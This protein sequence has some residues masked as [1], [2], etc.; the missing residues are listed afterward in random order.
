MISNNSGEY[1]YLIFIYAECQV[2]FG[3]GNVG[4]ASG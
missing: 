1:Y 2:S 3:A 4:V